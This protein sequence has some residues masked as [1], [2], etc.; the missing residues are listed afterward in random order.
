MGPRFITLL[1]DSSLWVWEH[2]IER[3]VVSNVGYLVS[4]VLSTSTSGGLPV[5]TMQEF[6]GDCKILDSFDVVTLLEGSTVIFWGDEKDRCLGVAS[7]SDCTE[8]F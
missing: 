1:E 4:T 7:V 5:L 3:A 8:F 6:L 2:G